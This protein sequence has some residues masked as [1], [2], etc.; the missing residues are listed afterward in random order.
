MQTL[1]KGN[2]FYSKLRKFREPKKC[3]V[4]HVLDSI[5]DDQKLIIL[6]YY[7]RFWREDLFIYNEQTQILISKNKGDV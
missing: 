6:K 3:E 5:Y 7:Y 4:L 2:V 1:K